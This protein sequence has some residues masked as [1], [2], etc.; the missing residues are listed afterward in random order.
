MKR[1]VI[2]FGTGI[3]FHGQNFTGAAQK[4][5]KDAISHSCLCGLTEIV[6]LK[7]LNDMIVEVTV[8]VPEPEKVNQGK[9]LEVI[10]FGRKTIKVINGGMQV[11]GL[12]IPALGDSDDS[13]VVANACVEV[14]VN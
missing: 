12:F 5:V 8:A 6:G 2:E 4:A 1:F 7:D 9:V 10:P 11:S 14:K 13:I 3:D